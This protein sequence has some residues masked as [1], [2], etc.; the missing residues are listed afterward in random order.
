M[1]DDYDVTV[2]DDGDTVTVVVSESVPHQ[3]L[4]GGETEA[5]LP[6]A[7]VA[8]PTDE[9][10]A[11][12]VGHALLEWYAEQQPTGPPGQVPIHQQ[13]ASQEPEP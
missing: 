1:S 6:L 13:Y 11:E 7:T 10:V 3:S 2:A 8:V 4:D 9:D 5:A 12:A